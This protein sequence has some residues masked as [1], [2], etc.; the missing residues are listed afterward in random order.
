MQ[1][2]VVWVYGSSAAGKETFLRFMQ[3]GDSEMLLNELGLQSHLVAICEESIDWV[4]QYDEDPKG[5]QRKLLPSVVSQQVCENS[6]SVIFIKGQDLDLNGGQ[7]MELKR[8]LPDCEHHIFFLQ[9]SIEEI[10]RRVKNK[11]WWN[12]EMD[13]EKMQSWLTYQM[14]FLKKLQNDFKITVLSAEQEV[15]YSI[16][17]HKLPE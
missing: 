5:F 2:K 17:G 10:V 15:D 11:S 12:K 16:I 13:K 14:S 9:V 4:A 3:A 6:N 7:L 8:M 1:S